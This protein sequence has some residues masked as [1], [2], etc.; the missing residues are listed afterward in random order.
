M[1]TCVDE[2]L[3]A[4]VSGCKNA[5]CET[6][7]ATMLLCYLICFWI[8]APC[9]GSRPPNRGS[10]AS[11]EPGVD[12]PNLIE[13]DIA[14]PPNVQGSS[15]ALNTF[16]KSKKALWPR[17]RV[18]YRIETYEWEEGLVEPVFLDSQIEN[19]TLALQRIETGVP[20]ID[21]K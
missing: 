13:G 21:F 6:Q 18:P 5:F 17:A 2:G 4:Q 1:D 7:K 8:L 19:I 10:F 14:L 20:C 16:L 9:K 11:P 3:G 15:S 12:T